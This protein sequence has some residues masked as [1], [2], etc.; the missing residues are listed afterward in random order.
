MRKEP[1]FTLT[2]FIKIYSCLN[3]SWNGLTMIHFIKLYNYMASI[4]PTRHEEDINGFNNW[5]LTQNRL[6]LSLQQQSNSC[7]AAGLKERQQWSIKFTDFCQTDQVIDAVNN[8]RGSTLPGDTFTCASL[9]NLA[10][11]S[12]TGCTPEVVWLICMDYKLK[13]GSTDATV[14]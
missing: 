5:V 1:C 6:V 3:G 14:V 13:M 8:T 10:F 9:S 11:R 2:L 7:T 4:L 12:D